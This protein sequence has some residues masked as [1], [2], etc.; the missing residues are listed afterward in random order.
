MKKQLRELIER[1]RQ[2]DSKAAEYIEGDEIKQ[3]KSFTEDTGILAELMYWQDTKQGHNYWK[4]IN[5]QLN[6]GE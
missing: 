4:N 2:I 1:I 6:K 5:E 3:L